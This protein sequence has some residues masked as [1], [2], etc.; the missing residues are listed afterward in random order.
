M[1]SLLRPRPLLGHPFRLLLS[2]VKYFAVLHLFWEYGYSLGPAQGP[3]MLP[4]IQVADEW[5]LTSKRHRHGR[6]VAVGDLVVYK[7]PIFPDMDGMKRVLGMPGDYVLIDSPESGSDAMI[8]VPQGHCWLVGD[9]LPTSRDSR[10]FG[11][12]PLALVSGKVIATLRS[13]GPGF[14]FKWITNPLK[15][16][17]STT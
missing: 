10:M 7:I 13:P 12:V 6:G 17:S 11:P 3:S 14:E 8:Q 5:M 2:T 1:A 15:S 4:T 9:N 16:Y